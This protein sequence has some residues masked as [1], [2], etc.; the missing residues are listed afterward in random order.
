M[1]YTLTPLN[2][3]QKDAATY[4]LRSQRKTGEALDLDALLMLFQCASPENSYFLAVENSRFKNGNPVW[5]F[6]R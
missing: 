4:L 6:S 2:R 1:T 5:G 3:T